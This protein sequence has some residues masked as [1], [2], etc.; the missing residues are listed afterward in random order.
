M[1][2]STKHRALKGVFCAPFWPPVLR[3]IYI[4]AR[5]I[6]YQNSCTQNT[7]SAIL[8]MGT[9]AHVRQVTSMVRL[10]MTSCYISSQRIDKLLEAN[11]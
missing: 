6:Q 11:F 7:L 4:M 2:F 10:M 3:N 5:I 1:S 8:L 9:H